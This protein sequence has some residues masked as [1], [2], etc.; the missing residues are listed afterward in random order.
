MTSFLSLFCFQGTVPASGKEQPESVSGRQFQVLHGLEHTCRATYLQEGVQIPLVMTGY[1]WLLLVISKSDTSARPDDI[2][3]PV[4]KVCGGQ[5]AVCS[6]ESEKQP[7]PPADCANKSTNSFRGPV[8]DPSHHTP[9]PGADLHVRQSAVYW[10]LFSLQ[11]H[12]GP[13]AHCE[14]CRSWTQQL[15]QG[16]DGGWQEAAEWRTRPPSASMRQQWR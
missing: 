8:W 6:H 1:D 3:D 16:A 9:T 4:L 13:H 11:E 12:C 2:T 7:W 15:N 10:G 5:L 14:V